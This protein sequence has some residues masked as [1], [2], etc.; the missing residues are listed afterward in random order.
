MGIAYRIT[1]DNSQNSV[2][3]GDKNEE[4]VSG[5]LEDLISTTDQL[6]DVVKQATEGAKRES[7][8]RLLDYV[9]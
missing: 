4:I 2:V 8:V 9:H 5:S 6:N 7:E 3:N 1:F